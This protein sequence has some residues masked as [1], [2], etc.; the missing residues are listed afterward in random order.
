MVLEILSGRPSPDAATGNTI[1]PELD[2][3]APLASIVP[4]RSTAITVR[5]NWRRASGHPIKLNFPS[6]TFTPRGAFEFDP[7][8]KWGEGERKGGG[9]TRTGGGKRK[10]S[11]ERIQWLRVLKR[12]AWRGPENKETPSLRV[13]RTN[14][15]ENGRLI[16][17]RLFCLR[18]NCSDRM[19]ARLAVLTPLEVTEGAYQ[20]LLSSVSSEEKENNPRPPMPI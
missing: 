15:L 5:K 1:V 19:R 12:L 18:R 20:V 13:M 2:S 7:A 4:G 8:R 3:F 6:T 9:R 17:A 10:R 16:E 11:G 14:H